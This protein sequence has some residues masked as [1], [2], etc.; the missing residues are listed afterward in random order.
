MLIITFGLDTSFP[1]ATIIFSNA[2]P[3]EYRGMAASIVMAIVNYSIP[4]GL[5]FAGTIETN[6]NHGGSMESDKLH[7]YRSALWFSV[8]LARVGSVS[9]SF[10]WVKI[11]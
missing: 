4:L 7:G 11:T 9:D 2:V 1:A 3:K 8:G 10:L 5:D 6:I